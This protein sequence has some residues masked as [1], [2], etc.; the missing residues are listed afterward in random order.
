LQQTKGKE[1][2]TAQRID[3]KKPVLQKQPAEAIRVLLIEDNPG[4]SEVIRIILDKARDIRFELT[5]TKSLSEGLDR[6]SVDGTDLILL[7]LKLPDS[8]GIE[9]FDKIYAHAQSVPIIVLTVTDNDVLALEAVQK[10]AQDY[11]V[12]EQVNAKSMQHAIRYAVERKRIEETL[13]ETNLFLQNILESS[14]AISILYT[15]REGTILYWNRGAENIFGYKAEEIIGNHKVDILYP[16]NDE[17]T[18]NKIEEVRSFIFQNKQGTRCEIQEITKDKRKLWIDLNLTPRFDATGEVSGILGVGQ[19]ITERKRMEEMLLKAAHEWRTTFDAISDVVCLINLDREIIR[20]NKAMTKLMKLPFTDI[21]EHSCCE[22]IHGTRD[23]IEGCP[24]ELMLKTRRTESILLQRGDR[25]FNISVD[26]LLDEVNNPIGGVHIITDIT[27]GKE[28]DQMKSELISNV[29]HELRTPLSTI[30]EG[31]AL[32]YDGALGPLQADQKE[33]LSRVKNNID[34][35]TRLINDLLDM[36]KI[37]AGRMELKKSSVDIPALVQEVLA[38]IQDQAKNKKIEFTTRIGKNMLPMYIDRDRICQVLTNLIA[39][40]IKF[41]PEHGCI[42]VGIKDREKEAQISVADNGVGIAAKNISGLFDRFSQFN[43]DYGPGERGTGLGLPISKEII[44]MHGGKIW[45][46]SELG[47]GSTF[48]FSL[49]RL[50]QD[51]I[52]RGYL[53]TGLREAADKN[54]P[55]S[56]VVVRMKNIEK[57]ARTHRMETVSEILQDIESLIARTLRRK[58]DIV[59]RYKYGEIIIAILMDTAKHDAL[60]VKERIKQAISDEMQEKKWPK[61]IELFLDIVTYPDDASDEVGLIK[62]ISKK[63]WGEEITD[64]ETKGGQDG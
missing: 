24:F 39:N 5:S 7:D 18:K 64:D 59:S 31:I 22:L 33:M 49:P 32:V 2:I 60:F 26:P 47:R 40:S 43:R 46:E 42:T 51:E 30:K 45:A 35:L 61:D 44:E 37:E 19:D 57:F 23:P 27:K 38:S 21:I 52:F 58:S 16:Q 54:C 55:L 48:I 34:R 63:L 3:K 25:W 62:K 8:Q 6:L 50:S 28:I 1:M 14:F 10:G 29:S 4:Y 12:K 41:T 36:S 13:R 56:L 20:C 53:T 11:L 9:T 15:D 17:K